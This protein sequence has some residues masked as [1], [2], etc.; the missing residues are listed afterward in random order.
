MT[1][2]FNQIILTRSRQPIYLQ[3]AAEFTRNISVGLWPVNEKIPVLEVLM[4]TYQ[5]SRMTIRNALGVLEDEQLISRSRGRG[6]FVK[7]RPLDVSELQIPTTWQEAVNLSDMLGTHS[8]TA[9][10][11]EIYHLPFMGMTCRGSPVSSYKYLCRLHSRDGIPYC[12][13]EVYVSMELFKKH[14]QAF[15]QSAAASVISR[16]P[17]LEVDESRQ[18]LTIIN[19]GFESANALK[20]DVGD[21]VAEVRRFACVNNEIIYYARLEFPTQF[22]KLDLDL[23]AS[24]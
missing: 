9:S 1:S 8:I 4:E 17:N 19:A 20:L 11:D 14:E 15:L 13:S 2:P 16:I 7:R 3:L 6:T 10:E 22:V 23:L 12:F 24:R 5:V 21:S 18:S